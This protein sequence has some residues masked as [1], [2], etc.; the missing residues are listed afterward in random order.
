MKYINFNIIKIKNKYKKSYKTKI[1]YKRGRYEN[2]SVFVNL[3]N[4][5]NGTYLKIGT[6]KRDGVGMRLSSCHP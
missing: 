3:F 5:L 2:F 6:I 4:F 1:K